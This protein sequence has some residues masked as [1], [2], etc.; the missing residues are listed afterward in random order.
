MRRLLVA[1]LALG[2]GTAAPVADDVDTAPDPDDTDV[3]PDDS[4]PDPLAD[5]RTWGPVTELTLRVPIADPPEVALDL[6]R[7]AVTQ[8][9]GDA[10][11]D[12]V[13]LSLD[14]IPLLE[15]ALDRIKSACGDDWRRDI[16]NPV[17][18]CE[19]TELGRSFRGRDG[20]WRTSPE[21]SLVSILTTTPANA[22]VDGTSIETLAL[23]ADTI[24]LGGG[25]G[26]ILADSLEIGRTSEF[27]DTRAVAEG[28][29]GGLLASHP[30]IPQD[31]RIPITLEDALTDLRTLGERLGP[32][33]LH[34]GVI[35]PSVPTYG[36]VL[37]DDFAMRASLVSNL[38]VLDG[39]DLDQGKDYIGL[40][41]DRTGPTFD[42]EVEFDFTDPAR[43]G[44]R[45]LVDDP[46]IDLRFGAEEN[47][48][49]IEACGGVATGRDCRNNQPGSPVG[50][51]TV[52]TT[53]PWEL[54][55]AI[56]LAGR[57]KYGGLQGQHCYLGCSLV[58]IAIGRSQD[59]PGFA[60]FNVLFSIGSPPE[61]QY[62]WELIDEVAQVRLHDGPGGVL[63]E[64][65]GDVA[66]TLTDVP[67]GLTAE[68]IA[69][70]IRPVLQAQNAL[71]SDFLLGD[72]R[73][74][75]GPVDLYYRRSEDG[76]PTIYWVTP[77]E[78][79]R[80][81][82]YARTG[83]YA[84]PELTVKRSALS[85][86]GSPDTTHEKWRPPPGDSVVYAEDEGGRL[87]RLVVIAQD[88]S[89]ADAEL[90]VLLQQEI[91]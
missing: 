42:D 39:L 40:I 79:D 84:D 35:D 63:A 85:L 37:A 88:L 41:L 21:L 72:F 48:R 53:Q 46:R 51:R 2:C 86:P 49:F 62:A 70:G 13:L 30:A 89:S 91:R 83:L 3:V 60:R 31:G 23:I 65:Q 90:T 52:W 6:D 43:F 44:V 12:I 68:G 73:K 8:L 45:G 20:T 27:L 10:A 29:R 26:Q 14:P 1:S 36:R 76:Q 54:E 24:G 32:S 78:I 50:T 34:P 5:G 71:M 47:D 87:F 58:E 64:G 66:F 81:W 15:S 38:R 25:F 67:V 55:H 17:F 61:P 59:P 22:D 75:S 28:M 56:G 33:G 11:A 18:D 9:F 57:Y 77:D 69:E 4:E 7:E 19:L 80:P 74:N 16:P 82:R